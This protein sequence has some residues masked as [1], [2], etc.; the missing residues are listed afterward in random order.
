MFKSISTFVLAAL[1]MVSMAQAAPAKQAKRMGQGGGMPEIDLD[2]SKIKFSGDCSITAH[3]SNWEDAMIPYGLKKNEFGF[4]SVECKDG[5]KS[6]FIL[7][8]AQMDQ[9]EEGIHMGN[10]GG[11]MDGTATDIFGMYGYY[12]DVSSFATFTGFAGWFPTGTGILAWMK[13]PTATPV[14]LFGLTIG[15]DVSEHYGLITI[16]KIS[17]KRFDAMKLRW[18]GFNIFQNQ[19]QGG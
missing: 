16:E 19:S 8:S 13:S 7:R 15:F 11:Y 3:M 14:V 10:V 5:S 1:T 4:G 17:K 12:K 2:I 6:Y 9:N 18:N